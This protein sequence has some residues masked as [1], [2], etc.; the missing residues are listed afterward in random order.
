MTVRSTL[1]AALALSLAAYAAVEQWTNGTA[2][3]TSAPDTRAVRRTASETAPQSRDAQSRDALSAD[4]LR[5]TIERPL[6]DPTRRARRIAPPPVIIAPPPQEPT[7]QVVAPDVRLI[8]IVAGSQTIA[9]LSRPGQQKSIQ[10]EV[11]SVIDGWQVSQ[12]SAS[13]LTLSGQG[14]SVSLR[15]ERKRN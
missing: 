11:G 13:T 1:L 10:V 14:Q 15:I 4:L 2:P 3:A 5:D 8:G 9:L 6:F 12:I 7:K